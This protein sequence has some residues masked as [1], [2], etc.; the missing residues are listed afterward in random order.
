VTTV[1]SPVRRGPQDKESTMG[2]LVVT[3]FI[4]LDGIIEDP[5]GAEGTAQGGWSWSSRARRGRTC[6]C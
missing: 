4:S 5:G 2:K 1:S 6:C 3:E